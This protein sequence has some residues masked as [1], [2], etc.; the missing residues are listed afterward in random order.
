MSL[1]SDSQHFLLWERN[2]KYV[3]KLSMISCSWQGPLRYHLLIPCHRNYSTEVGNEAK[4]AERKIFLTSYPFSCWS[5]LREMGKQ[6]LQSSGCLA[7]SVYL[8]FISVY[9]ATKANSLCTIH[10]HTMESFLMIR[11]RKIL[12]NM[13]G[14][15]QLGILLCWFSQPLALIITQPIF[16]HETKQTV[17]IS[18]L[19]Q[20]VIINCGRLIDLSSKA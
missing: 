7:V 16:F 12:F 18:W 10:T 6:L 15:C 19:L 3:P 2:V 5:L 4:I 17:L 20:S 13:Y 8:L 1:I 9:A 11:S 14:V